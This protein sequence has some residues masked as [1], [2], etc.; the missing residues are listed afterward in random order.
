MLA[1][2][3]SSGEV[4][5]T[6]NIDPPYGL[7]EVDDQGLRSALGTEGKG[8]P[9]K[10]KVFRVLQPLTVYRVWDADNAASQCGRWWSFNPP[11]GPR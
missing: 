10:A 11:A 3:L 9:C 4:K 5:C 6:G 7:A 2:A 8:D 1:W